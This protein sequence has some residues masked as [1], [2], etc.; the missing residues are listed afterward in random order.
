M[1][2]FNIDCHIAVIA[3]IKNILEH[4]GH[5]V[6]HWSISGHRHIFNYPSCPSPVITDGNWSKIDEQMCN[7][8][9][10][11]HKDELDI[12]DAFIVAYPTAFLK[13][14]ERFNKPIIVVIPIRYD[15][16]LHKDVERL[17]WLE[18]SLKNNKNLILIANNEF[19]VHYCKHFFGGDVELIP[20]LC[21]YTNEKHIMSNNNSVV[22]SKNLVENCGLIHQSKL[23]EY[24]YKDLYSYKSIVHFPYHNSTMSLFEQTTAGV[25]IVMPSLKFALQLINQNW[26]NGGTPLFSELTFGGVDQRR[27]RSNFLNEQWLKTCDFY[28]G[29]YIVNYFNSFEELRTILKSDNLQA[30]N[31]DKEKIY[32]QWSD[33]LKR[34]SS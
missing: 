2:F 25:P 8:F 4:L 15:F 1:K 32:S 7:N 21:D 5:T 11:T 19:D 3:D 17:A 13:L 34:I 22:F 10:E 14:Y 28:N 9:Y 27:N 33:I 29:T 30:N 26:P 20:S 16:P 6:D 18:D 24:T 31:K 23:G 12:Y